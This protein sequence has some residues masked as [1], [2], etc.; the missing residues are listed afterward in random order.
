MF[1]ISLPKDEDPWGWSLLQVKIPSPVPTGSCSVF[2][3]P[4]RPY[5]RGS[6]QYRC[7]PL[8]SHTKLIYMLHSI[9]STQQIKFRLLQANQIDEISLQLSVL[10]FEAA[11][12][13][14]PNANSHCFLPYHFLLKWHGPLAI[15][16]APKHAG[17][18]S[19]VYCEA[20]RIPLGS[21][22]TWIFSHNLSLSPESKWG[23]NYIHVNLQGMPWSEVVDKLQVRLARKTSTFGHE[24]L[25]HC[26]LD[27]PKGPHFRDRLSN[28]TASKFLQ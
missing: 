11:S 12:S 17:S 6:V 25:V 2:W 3:C 8:Q 4:W 13:I 22:V 1:S 15:S 20:T 19:G 23:V 26:S 24:T 18:T 10:C 16:W 5:V 27:V 21:L 9:Q 7:F 14:Y 28:W